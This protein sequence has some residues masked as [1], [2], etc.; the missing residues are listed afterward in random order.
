MTAGSRQEDLCPVCNKPWLKHT[1]SE[2]DKCFRIKHK[3]DTGHGIW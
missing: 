3:K 2:Q 1:Q